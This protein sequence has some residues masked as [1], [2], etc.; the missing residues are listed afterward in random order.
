[1]GEYAPVEA[2]LGKRI[3]ESAKAEWGFQNRTDIAVTEDGERIVVQWYRL[4]A[5]GERR[6]RVMRPLRE[7]AAAKGIDIPRIRAMDLDG[8]PAWVVYDQLPGV[9]LP[10]AGDARPGGPRFPAMAR[11]MGEWLAV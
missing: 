2:A 8:D 7:P 1:M 3:T 4:R 10:A 6:V 9:P 11:L 5:D